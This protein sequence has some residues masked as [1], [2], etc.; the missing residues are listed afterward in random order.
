MIEDGSGIDCQIISPC[1]DFCTGAF[2]MLEL[3]KHKERVI[4]II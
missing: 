1:A 3:Q 4:R 2:A